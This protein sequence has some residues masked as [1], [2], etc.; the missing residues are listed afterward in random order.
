MFGSL[1][2]PLLRPGLATVAIFSALAAWNEFLLAL[3]YIQ[4][5]TRGED[6]DRRETRPEERQR[7]AAE[8]L[9]VAGA[10]DPRRLEQ[11]FG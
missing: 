5:A 7:E 8:Q 2:L 11:L 6:R 1:A 4:D 3:L 10:V 9:A